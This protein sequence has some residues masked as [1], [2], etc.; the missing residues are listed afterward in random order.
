MIKVAIVNSTT[1]NKSFP[2]D[3]EINILSIKKA[4]KERRKS[5]PKIEKSKS[6]VASAKSQ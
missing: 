3:F 4:H 1:Q 5:S 2:I 6:G